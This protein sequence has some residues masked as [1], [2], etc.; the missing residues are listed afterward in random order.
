MKR[1][2]VTVVLSLITYC[3]QV[4]SASKSEA[5]H[6]QQHKLFPRV[7]PVVGLQF[8]EKSGEI[9]YSFHYPYIYGYYYPETYGY[10]TSSEQEKECYTRFEDGTFFYQCD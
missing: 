7:L 5:F 9:P 10:S 1:V 8:D 2:I 3:S 4:S 6:V